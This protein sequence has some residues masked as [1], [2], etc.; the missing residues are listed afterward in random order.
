MGRDA[1]A[2]VANGDG[3]RSVVATESDFDGAGIGRVLHGVVEQV[4]K[5]AGEGLGIS[6]YF[7]GDASTI[8]GNGVAFSLRSG[9]ELIDCAAYE[10]DA[11]T[12]LEAVGAGACLHAAEIEQRFD[13]P[14][15]AVGGTGLGLIADDAPFGAEGGVVA[16]HIGEL[17]QG[18]ERRAELVGDGG[19][20]V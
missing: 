17:A 4:P 12:S 16:Q 11:V 2:V 18:G 9:A 8:E 15:Q 14:G 19:D 20:E 6:I 5:G 13:Q 3:D 1:D 10:A 7:G